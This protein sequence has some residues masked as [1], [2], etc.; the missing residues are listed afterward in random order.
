MKCMMY[1]KNQSLLLYFISF[2]FFVAGAHMDE[3]SQVDLYERVVV[4][5]KNWVIMERANGR[6]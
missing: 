3:L 2:S 1:E 6:Y 4:V 5:L